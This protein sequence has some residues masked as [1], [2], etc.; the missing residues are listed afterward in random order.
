MSRRAVM[1]F[2]DFN[3]LFH[4]RIHF[5]HVNDD[6]S[7]HRGEREKL[8]AP[9]FN[10]PNPDFAFEIKE[11]TAD[12]VQEGL[13]QYI[14]ENPVHLAVMVTKQRGFF[15]SLFHRSEVKQVVLSPEVPLLVLHED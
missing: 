8:F 1:K 12:T 15:E 7:E 6:E 9:L 11:V 5:V 14:R 4:G 3:D 10:N 13:Q 2:M